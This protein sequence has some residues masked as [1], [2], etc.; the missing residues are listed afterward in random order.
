MPA[1]PSVQNM[2]PPFG[3]WVAVFSPCSCALSDKSRAAGIDCIMA[4]LERQGQETERGLDAHG[5]ASI[6]A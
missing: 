5:M 3:H 6:S 2:H 4:G 1:L